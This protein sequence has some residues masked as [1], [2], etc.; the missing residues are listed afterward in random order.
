MITYVARCTVTPEAGGSYKYLL[1]D[2]GSK[3]MDL[4]EHGKKK[5][6]AFSGS[7][8]LSA[9]CLQHS[10]R[11]GESSAGSHVQPSAKSF[12][13]GFSRSCKQGMRNSAHQCGCHGATSQ[14]ATTSP[15][16]VCF[17]FSTAPTT[18][19]NRQRCAPT[20]HRYHRRTGS[21]QQI[22]TP[23]NSVLALCMIVSISLVEAVRLS[24]YTAASGVEYPPTQQHDE[25][26]SRIRPVTG[27]AAVRRR[28]S[29]SR[30]GLVAFGSCCVAAATT[31][32]LLQ[33]SS[34]DCGSCL[35]E[36]G[37]MCGVSDAVLA[38]PSRRGERSWMTRTVA[39]DLFVIAVRGLLFVPSHAYM[40]ICGLHSTPAV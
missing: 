39:H 7:N 29:S 37:C 35:G 36:W 23:R 31:R 11:R 4:S 14:S 3:R 40:S 8:R 13:M 6:G 27:S 12:N 22:I 24:T 33:R 18:P 16:Q 15:P 9:L 2:R 10:M 21:R 25:R 20:S 38:S 19:H 28:S 30:G 32:Q 26:L 17:V 1:H 5:C 34:R